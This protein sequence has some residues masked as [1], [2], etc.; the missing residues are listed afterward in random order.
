MTRNGHCGARVIVQGESFSA[1]H[2]WHPLGGGGGWKKEELE[3]G[4]EEQE[5]EE[6]CYSLYT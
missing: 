6:E 2:P 4:E 3:E 5:E 1:C